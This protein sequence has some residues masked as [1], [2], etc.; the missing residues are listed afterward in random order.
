M[1]DY[2]N[3]YMNNTQT[4]E[5][6]MRRNDGRVMHIVPYTAKKMSGGTYKFNLFDDVDAP[7]FTDE[8]GHGYKTDDCIVYRLFCSFGSYDSLCDAMMK[9]IK[10]GS[11]FGYSDGDF[12]RITI[13]GRLGRILAEKTELLESGYTGKVRITSY[14]FKSNAPDVPGSFSL[15][16][17]YDVKKT[18][19]TIYTFEG[20]KIKA[21]EGFLEHLL[22]GKFSSY[23]VMKDLDDV[24]LVVRE[25][26]DKDIFGAETS[27]YTIEEVE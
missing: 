27:T 6:V 13:Y 15:I 2:V 12:V 4:G 25:A 10:D 22:E 24:R 18:R 9:Y 17:T 5:I 14:L 26:W 16:S 11:V 20:G 21:R 19:V 7:A 23:G 1:N 8:F 3:D